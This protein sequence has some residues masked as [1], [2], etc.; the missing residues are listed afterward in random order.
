[1]SNRAWESLVIR[2]QAPA[3]RAVIG[4]APANQ[5]ERAERRTMT[6]QPWVVFFFFASSRDAGAARPAAAQKEA[7]RWTGRWTLD[8]GRWTYVSRS[9][10]NAYLRA[11]APLAKFESHPFARPLL[12]VEARDGAASLR[13]WASGG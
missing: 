2:R 1:V 8:A 6:T 11:A 5:W 9:A 7:G 10:G 4:R 13:P 12:L 3:T